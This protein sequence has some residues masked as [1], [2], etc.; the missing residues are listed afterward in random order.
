LLLHTDRES[1]IFVACHSLEPIDLLYLLEIL[2][3]I[4][5]LRFLRVNF[6]LKLKL[7]F[8]EC[9]DQLL[10]LNLRFESYNYVVRKS[11]EITILNLV[12]QLWDRL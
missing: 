12:A 7:E 10:K 4:H 11:E 9:T 6:E 3:L 1:K 2:A 8:L 5:E